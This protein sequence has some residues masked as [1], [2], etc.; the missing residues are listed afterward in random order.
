MSEENVTNDA[1][2]QESNEAITDSQFDAYFESRGQSLEGE[3]E[4]VDE[5]QAEENESQRLDDSQNEQGDSSSETVN[6]S[7]DET[8]EPAKDSPEKLVENYNAAMREAREK[9]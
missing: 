5:L 1:P 2:V 3:S 4:S 8:Q 6:D 9:R 7:Q